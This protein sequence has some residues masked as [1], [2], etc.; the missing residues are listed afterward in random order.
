MASFNSAFDAAELDLLMG[1]VL[2]LAA[3]SPDCFESRGLVV[4]AEVLML[5]VVVV[6]VE[7]EDWGDGAGA[8]AEPEV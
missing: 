6:V 1:W 2:V 8:G 5:V 7:E 4:E 3:F